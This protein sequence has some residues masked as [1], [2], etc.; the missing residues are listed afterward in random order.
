[1]LPLQFGRLQIT[2]CTLTLHPPSGSFIC[3][4]GNRCHDLIRVDKLILRTDHWGVPGDRLAATK[5]QIK[6]GYFVGTESDCLCY[7]LFGYHQ[8]RWIR[9]GTVS[10]RIAARHTA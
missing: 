2:F 8:Q 4:Y 9:Y 5:S 3:G 7:L 1:M 10:S 6:G